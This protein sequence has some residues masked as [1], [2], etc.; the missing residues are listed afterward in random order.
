VHRTLAHRQTRRRFLVAGVG[1]FGVL[2]ASHALRGMAR[3]VDD[4]RAHRATADARMIIA[5][6][7]AARLCVD[8]IGTKS[9]VPPA[10]LAE[11]LERAALTV[12]LAAAG[13]VCAVC[14][15]KRTVYGLGW[16]RR[17]SSSNAR[18]VC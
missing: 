6:I 14:S 12:R 3:A 13:A 16:R 9:G 18:E 4:P 15:R 5:S 11:I 17:P 1:A 7:R 2:A 8:C 10:R